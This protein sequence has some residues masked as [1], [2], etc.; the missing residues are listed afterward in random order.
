M[1]P[2]IR[3]PDETQEQFRARRKT[4]NSTPLL[5]TMF[6]P[7]FKGTYVNTDRGMKKNIRLARKKADKII[8]MELHFQNAEKKNPKKKTNKFLG[9]KI[10]GGNSTIARVFDEKY[11]KLYGKKE[12]SNVAV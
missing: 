5:P 8:K 6:W 2:N 9:Y 1:N 7:W 4:E 11:T 10:L 12:S 3:K